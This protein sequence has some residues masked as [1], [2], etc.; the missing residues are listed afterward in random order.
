LK[1]FEDV[2]FGDVSRRTYA[3]GQEIKAYVRTFYPSLTDHEGARVIVGPR[4]YDRSP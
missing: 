4:Q 1:R 3:V 2:A